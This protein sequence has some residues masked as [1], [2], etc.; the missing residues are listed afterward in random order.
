MVNHKN[1]PLLLIFKLLFLNLVNIL[2]LMLALSKQNKNGLIKSIIFVVSLTDF[3]FSFRSEASLLMAVA[4]ILMS[5]QELG[6][7]FP[8][9][10]IMVFFEEEQ[11]HHATN[12][13]FI[14]MVILHALLS[15][16]FL[17]ASETIFHEEHS[18]KAIVEG[19]RSRP[20]VVNPDAS[21]LE[22]S[23]RSIFKKVQIY[24]PL[25]QLAMVGLTITSGASTII[26]K[27][28]FGSTSGDRSSAL[29]SFSSLTRTCYFIVALLASGVLL[30]KHFC[31]NSETK[32][33]HY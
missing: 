10:S 14:L 4:V 1:G 23:M 12:L 8:T 6:L 15:K 11:D 2:G 32:G 30:V 16:G 20:L 31:T 5:P 13:L 21:R 33:K 22:S 9:F 3:M 18:L 27:L 19:E 17:E 7:I 25:L 24:F 28:L 26:D 29:G